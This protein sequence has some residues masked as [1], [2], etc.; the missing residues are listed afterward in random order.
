M[1]EQPTY[2][3]RV[4]ALEGFRY[5]VL[6]RVNAL[7][8]M[9]L[10]AWATLLKLHS[11]DPLT[12]AKDMQKQWLAAAKAPQ[13]NFIGVDPAHLDAVSQ[14][15]E[16]ALEDLTAEFVRMAGS[17]RPGTKGSSGRK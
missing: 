14:E 16:A 3:A 5:S 7:Q 1:P 10:S 8:T 11:D 2:E 17:I 15:Y 12:T 9:L 13:R 6:G 4:R